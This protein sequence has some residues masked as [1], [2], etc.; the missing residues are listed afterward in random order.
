MERDIT[1]YMRTRDS[2]LRKN[3]GL[4]G[5]ERF[6]YLP[7]S[8]R[9]RC[10]AGGQLNYGGHNT[11]N[12]TYVYIGTSK[13]CG[14]CAQKAQLHQFTAEVSCH[15]H[16]RTGTATRQR[17]GKYACLC[18]GT[19]RKKEGGNAVRRTQES[20]RTASSAPTGIKVCSRAVLHGSGCAKY[21]A[22]SPV[23]QPDAKTTDPR[24]DVGTS[25]ETIPQGRYSP[26]PLPIPSSPFST[27][28]GV[29]T[30]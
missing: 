26:H 27:P 11:R 16:A 15:P 17:P 9:Y 6:T 19:A 3:S 10:P 28:T 8:N 25:Q 20:D 14:G 4:Y 22:T 23:P 1:P 5:P 2:A 21:Q 7:E 12:R 18:E 24:N 29:C 30:N 13:R